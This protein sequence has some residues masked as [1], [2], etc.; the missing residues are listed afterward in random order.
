[1]NRESW[2]RLARVRDESLREEH[3]I[4]QILIAD[5]L[6][7]KYKISAQMYDHQFRKFNLDVDPD[8]QAEI[9]RSRM[10]EE[11]TLRIIQS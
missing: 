10:P 6:T 3:H 9:E 11:L 1:M 2:T 7:L 8:V 4:E 5:R